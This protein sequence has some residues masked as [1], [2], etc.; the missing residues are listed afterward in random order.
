[1]QDSLVAPATIAHSFCTALV[2]DV[3]DVTS[4]L[5]GPMLATVEEALAGTEAA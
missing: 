2:A 3:I 5:A 4:E 1:V